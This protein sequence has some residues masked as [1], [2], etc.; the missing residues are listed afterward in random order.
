MNPQEERLRK[1][2]NQY[3][4]EELFKQLKENLHHPSFDIHLGRY[5]L[6]YQIDLLTT[7]A[8][9]I[10]LEISRLASIKTE[11][12]KNGEFT[13]GKIK[14][15]NDIS[16]ECLSMVMSMIRKGTELTEKIKEQEEE[17]PWS[18]K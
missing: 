6:S 10:D 14:A 2:L 4:Q 5:V 13:K 15:M 11:N 12:T 16:S 1:E 8:M 3:V 17:I 18:I 7:M 9:N